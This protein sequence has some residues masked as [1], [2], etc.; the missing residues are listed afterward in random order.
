MCVLCLS[1]RGAN[2]NDNLNACESL[3]FRWDPNHSR[4]HVI[5]SDQII[6]NEMIVFPNSCFNHP[7]Y[8][9]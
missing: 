7:T 5:I 1:N 4:M 9:L 6:K 8:S 3:C 2:D